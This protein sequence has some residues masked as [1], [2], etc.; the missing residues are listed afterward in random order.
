M[1]MVMTNVAKF[2]A[3]LKMPADVLLEQLKA[4]G[5]TKSSP[6]DSLTEAD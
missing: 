5:V 1:T 2:A 4:A 3:E 6:D